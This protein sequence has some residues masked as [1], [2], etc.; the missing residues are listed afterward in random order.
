MDQCVQQHCVSNDNT[1]AQHIERECLHRDPLIVLFLQYNVLLAKVF[2]PSL[3]SS[4]GQ[5]HFHKYQTKISTIMK[6]PKEMKTT[7]YFTQDFLNNLMFSFSDFHTA[8]TGKCHR[9]KGLRSKIDKIKKQILLLLKKQPL[10]IFWPI[11]PLDFFNN[12]QI[13]FLI[14]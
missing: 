12:K 7:K 14:L 8:A 3:S 13:Y 11:C 9:V 1:Q 4:R 5:I 10:P 6:Y 2:L